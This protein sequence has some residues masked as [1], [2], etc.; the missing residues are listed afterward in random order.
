MEIVHFRNPPSQL[1]K[2]RSTQK[3]SSALTEVKT[4]IPAVLHPYL[5][6]NAIIL[7]A[8]KIFLF[9]FKSLLKNP[10][11]APPCFTPRDFEYYDF[12]KMH[13]YGQGV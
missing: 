12:R 6:F 5:P 4:V 11:L 2:N 3:H 1:L 7:F 10:P 8:I 13:F 9:R